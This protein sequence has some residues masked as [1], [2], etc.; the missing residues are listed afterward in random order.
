MFSWLSRHRQHLRHHLSNY[1]LVLLYLELQ[2]F[3]YLPQYQMLLVHY[4]Q[5]FSVLV[6]DLMFWKMLLVLVL[7]L[8]V[9]LVLML[10]VVLLLLIQNHLNLYP[11]H[12]Y[13]L[14]L[15]LGLFLVLLVVVVVL[16]AA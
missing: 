15:L 1:S 14:V 3:F 11:D 5:L 12:R 16:I 2:F 8:V 10:L 7:L 4:H 9:L 13:L 6:Q